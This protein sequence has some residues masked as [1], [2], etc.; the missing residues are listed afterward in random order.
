MRKLA[1]LRKIAELQPIPDADLIETAIIDGW[2]VVVKKGEFQVG[3]LALYL[4]IDSWVS[5]E[6]AP[7]LSKGKIPREYMGISGERLRTV[8]LRGQ[9]SQG[10]LLPLSAI[11][12][13]LVDTAV[14]MHPTNWE[15]FIGIVEEKW[16]AFKEFR[17]VDYSER[18]G[19]VKW[20]APIPAELAGQVEGPFPTF[21]PKTDQER[22][23]NLINEIFVDNLDSEYEVSMKLDGT[24]CTIYH[25]NGKFG[26]CSRNWEL[27]IND[28]NKHNT[29]VRIA[30]DTLLNAELPKL[31]NYA[32]QG[33]LMGPGIQ[34]N[35][36]GLKKHELFVFD[37]YDID[38]QRYLTPKERRA[39]ISN[40][41]NI[42]FNGAGKLWHV[43]LLEKDGCSWTLDAG[44][45]GNCKHFKL[46][47]LGIL[48]IKD[49][50]SAA[51]GLSLNHK[52]REGLV[53]KRDDGAFSFKAIANNFLLKEE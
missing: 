24:S 39:F 30:H 25:F 46:R 52:I 33:E 29:L 4:E 18:L 16:H 53:F 8:R 22:C 9:I 5:T 11:W 12:E 41:Q 2:T 36:E 31:G 51:E 34:G 17:E 15:S 19:V 14:D 47:D 20:E 42:T 23:Q 43:P 21:I 27:K 7:F 44:I 45:V 3:Q 32:I 40:I 49:L 35:R 10:L 38:K 6:I 48:N 50:L 1:T 26:V 37:V 28:E 13:K